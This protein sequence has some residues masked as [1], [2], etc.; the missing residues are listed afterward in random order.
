[1]KYNV[2]KDRASDLWKS[3]LSVS[4]QG[5]KKGRGKRMG[6][7]K[8][9]NMGQTLGDGKLQVKYPGLNEDIPALK[10]GAELPQIRVI[11]EDVDRE[12]RLTEI[13]NKMDRF[14][15]MTVSPFERGFSGSSLAGK[16][17]GPPESYDDG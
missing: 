14:K 2:I 16:P 11:G 6:R 8:D 3:V 12:K 7:A 5:S 4:N 15:R 1:M 9:L 13:R 17:L 10:S